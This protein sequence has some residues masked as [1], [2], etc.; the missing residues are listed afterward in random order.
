MRGTGPV[1]ISE[2]NGG[3]ACAWSQTPGRRFPR[4]AKGRD[5]V[6]SNGQDSGTLQNDPGRSG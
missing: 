1:L 3:G 2:L 6:E 5:L 4:L